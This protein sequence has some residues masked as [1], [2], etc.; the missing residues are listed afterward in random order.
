MALFT[1]TKVIFE[2][3]NLGSFGDLVSAQPEPLFQFDFVHGVL[4]AFSATPI[5][6]GTGATVDT[7]LSRLRVQ[8]GTTA[9]TGSS[10]FQSYRPAKFSTG[11]GITARFTAIF[12]TPQAGNVQEIGMMSTTDGFAF[13]YNGTAF[14]ILHRN[15]STGSL[16]ETWTAQTAW[17][18]DKCDGL[19]ASG[20]NWVKTNG[21][22]LMIRYPYGFGVVDFYVMNSNNGEWILCHQ[23]QYTNS[24]TNLLLSQPTLFFWCRCANTGANTTNVTMFCGNVGVFLSGKREFTLASWGIDT[25]RATVTTEAAILNIRSA[26][27]FNGVQ[28][29]GLLRLRSISFG[30]NLGGANPSGFGTVRIKKGV[31]LGG[32]PVYTP[33]SGSTADNGITLTAA[34]SIASYDTAATTVSGGTMQFNASFNMNQGY[35]IDMTPYF[36]FVNPAEI[37]TISITL[38][39][40]ATAFVAL[41][42][43]EDL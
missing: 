1:T 11:Q 40:S 15:S 2:D 22:L 36:L 30:G 31:T 38:S 41:N 43:Q 16:V 27:T 7:T 32:S 24:A 8:S 5:V 6:S 17:N 42:W 28:N 21:N 23:I 9:T 29:R 14:G 3:S 10:R 18:G 25:S 33:I 12:G 39:A 35:Q 20:F 13:G 37:W 19:G 26:T 4:A 34:Q